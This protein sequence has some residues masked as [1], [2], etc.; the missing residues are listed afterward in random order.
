MSDGELRPSLG[1]WSSIVCFKAAVVEM[2]D[3]LGPQGAKIALTAAG[4]RRGKELAESLGIEL[5]MPLDAAV[6]K[7]GQALGPDGTRLCIVNGAEEVDG[8]I[9]VFVEETVCMAG[10]AQGT[11]RECSFTL[12]AVHGALEALTGRQLKARHT[13]SPWRGDPADVFEFTDRI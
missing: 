5:G 3:A 2:E 12:G 11:D 4:R 10:E 7:L 1:E 6:A 8:T 13:E 9:R